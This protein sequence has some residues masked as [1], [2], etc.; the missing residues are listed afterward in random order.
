MLELLNRCRCNYVSRKSIVHLRHGEQGLVEIITIAAELYELA[1]MTA[2]A[3]PRRQVRHIATRKKAFETT[4]SFPQLNFVQQAQCSDVSS[5][6]N[7]GK[8]V[9]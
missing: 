9:F 4:M 2:S 7:R 5:Q 8:V 6:A 1:T 3:V